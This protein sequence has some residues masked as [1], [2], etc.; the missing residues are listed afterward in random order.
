ML[1]VGWVGLAFYIYHPA[2]DLTRLEVF[3]PDQNGNRPGPKSNMKPVY[4]VLDRALINV[5][6]N[7]HWALQALKIL[8]ICAKILR[9]RK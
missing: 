8:N 5:S 9:R 1:G 6:N 4:I 3:W 7:R 2:E